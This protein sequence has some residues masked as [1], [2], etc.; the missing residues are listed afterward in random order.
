M[1]EVVYK[2]SMNNTDYYNLDLDLGDLGDEL[3]GALGEDGFYDYGWNNTALKEHWVDIGAEYV[4][5]EL[6]N[7]RA[8]DVTTWN[9]ANLVLSPQ[10][11]SALK[12]TLEPYGEFL[13]LTIGDES[14]HV[15]NCL[16]VVDVDKS[17]SQ[18]NVVNDLWMGV[19]SIGFDAETVRNNIIF[20]TRFDR[21]SALYCND[22]FKALIEKFGLEG[23]IFHEDLLSEF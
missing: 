23:L 22:E 8:P 15:F 10:A 11:Y 2:L 1:A 20:K 17:V 13:P 14:Y 16:K 6:N 12:E 5:V 3:E 4:D 7:Q 18:A 19:K 9:G 21:C